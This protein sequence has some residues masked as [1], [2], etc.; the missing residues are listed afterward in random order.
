MNDA[1]F[2]YKLRS[3]EKNMKFVEMKPYEN[4][5]RAESFIKNV[6]KDIDKGNVFFWVIETKNSLTKV[7]TICLWSFSK[8]N[9][10]AEIGYELLPSYQKKGYAN[11]AMPSVIDFAKN[12]LELEKIH[13]ITHEGHQSSIKL[14]LRNGFKVLG[15]VNALIPNAEDGPEMKLFR[16]IL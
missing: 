1:S 10:S 8:E 11:E 12:K 3:N 16:K 6:S 2:I 9:Q 13:A 15:K 4:I 7:G 5:Q 14:L